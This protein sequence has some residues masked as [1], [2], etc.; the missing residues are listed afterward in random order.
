MR[1]H[2]YLIAE[3]GVN[4]EGNLDKAIEMVENVAK[5]GWDA[6]KFQT[7]TADLLASRD[8]SAAYWDTSE[9]HEV[10]QYALFSKFKSFSASEYQILMDRCSSLG[11]DFL[12][13]AFDSESLSYFGPRMPK[14]KIASAD[15]TN[16][17]LIR[18]AATFGKPLLISCGAANLREVKVAAAVARKS[19]ARTTL[20]H[21]VLNYPT[22]PE[23]ANL[24]GL[25]ELRENFADLQIGYSDHTRYSENAKI[26]PTVAAYILGAEIIEKHFTLDRSLPGNDH[27]HAAD[28]DGL[29]NIRSQ[30]EDARNLLGGDIESSLAWQTEARQH[31]RRRICASRHLESGLVITE[32]D[33]IPLRASIGLEVEDWDRVLG[34]RL[35]S[36]VFRGQPIQQEALD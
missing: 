31:A 8:H 36:P 12:T 7:Y 14:I 5:S 34:R 21:C 19:G 9:E 13:T 30:I 2:P 11:I 3:I 4:H 16:L 32:S 20:L 26:Q 22:I 24:N 6:A 17:P 18:Q 1:S 27:Y 35:N 29:V 10:S 33:L 23:R 25:V 15:I 28:T